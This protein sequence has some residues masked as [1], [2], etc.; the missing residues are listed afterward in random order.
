M[1]GS[2]PECT[3]R[4]IPRRLHRRRRAV[5]LVPEHDW[6]F[7]RHPPLGPAEHYGL[8]WEGQF[9]VRDQSVNSKLL[10]RPIGRPQDVLYDTRYG[11]HFWHYEIAG[12]RAK[13][14]RALIF[15]NPNSVQRDRNG[16]PKNDPDIFSFQLVHDPKPC[17][18]PHCEILTFRNGDQP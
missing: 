4:D 9:S 1:L 15:P 17:M 8:G 6:L 12:F 13:E 10:N 11:N 14:I 16:Q 3:I 2:E 7:M 18:Y 5:R